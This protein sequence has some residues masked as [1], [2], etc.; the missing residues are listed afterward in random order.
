M[1]RWEEGAPCLMQTR[2]PWARPRARVEQL[3]IEH[4]A[5]SEVGEGGMGDLH[6]EGEEEDR[7]A[8]GS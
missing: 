3:S 5:W 2:R 4:R 8:R 6:G 1:G 7:E